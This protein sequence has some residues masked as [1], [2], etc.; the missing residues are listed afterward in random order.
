MPTKPTPYPILAM[1]ITRPSCLLLLTFQS[2]NTYESV[3]T[4]KEWTADSITLLQGCYDCKDL[5]S[6]RSTS[7]NISTQAGTITWYINFCAHSIIPSKTVTIV[8]NSKPWITKELKK[9]LNKKKRTFFTGSGP[10]TKE[11]SNEV[12]RA[13]KIAKLRYKDEVQ[14]KFTNGNHNY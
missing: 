11:V 10:E 9:I 1:L 13:I 2:S 3:R 4:I 7:S 5:D 6:L 8:P 14:W 12:K